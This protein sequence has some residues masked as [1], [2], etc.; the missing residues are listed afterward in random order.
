M[1]H[2]ELK[3]SF[4]QLAQELSP[5]L[6]RYLQRYV[7]NRTVADDLLQESLIRIARGLPAFEGK[8]R[9]KTWAF[10]IATHVAADY[11]RAP[12]RRHRVVDVDEAAAIPDPDRP[13]DERIVIDEMNHCVRQVIESL[14]DDYRASLLLHDLEGC[15]L[16]R[17]PTSAGLRW[18]R[19]R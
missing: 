17:R 16:R 5:A 4:E 8:S 13:I 19:R 9:L 7:G 15:P 12:E 10:S 18:P 11:F 14:P 3:P 1:E 6:L 2:S